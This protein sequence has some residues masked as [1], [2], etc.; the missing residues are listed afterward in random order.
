MAPLTSLML[1]VRAAWAAGAMCFTSVISLL[2][3]PN[4]LI[5]SKAFPND[6][7]FVALARKSPKERFPV[8]DSFVCY[9]NNVVGKA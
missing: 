2:T 8:N 3:L 6:V 4:A 1:S 9:T 7:P 5:M